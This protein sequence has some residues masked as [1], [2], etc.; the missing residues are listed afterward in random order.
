MQPGQLRRLL[1][2]RGIVTIVATLAAVAAFVA[3]ETVFGALLAG[4]AITN[5][6][7][8]VVFVRAGSRAAP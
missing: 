4:L 8:I 2:L 3:G 1:I 7:L 5:T 6:V